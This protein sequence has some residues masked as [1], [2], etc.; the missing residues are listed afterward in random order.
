MIKELNLNCP[1]KVYE[2]SE[3]NIYYFYTL[4]KVRYIAYFTDADEYFPDFYLKNNIY[5]FG[6]EPE[7]NKGKSNRI[8]ADNNIKLTLISI[9]QNFFKNSNNVLTFVADISDLKQ[10]ARNRLFEIWKNQYDIKEQF[11]KYDI[12]IETDDESYYSSMLIN[13]N[14]MHKSEYKKAFLQTTEELKK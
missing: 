7:K 3:K 1:Y 5:T 11:E 13:R 2:D 9:I 14:N 12:E 10:K 6:F 8:L 4:T